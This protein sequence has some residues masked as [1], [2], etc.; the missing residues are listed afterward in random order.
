MKNDIKCPG[1]ITITRTYSSDNTRPV[2]I[3]VV[4][5][6][7]RIHVIEVRM[8]LEAFSRAVLGQGHIECELVGNPEQMSNFGSDRELVD[9]RIDLAEHKEKNLSELKDLMTR[10][11]ASFLLDG[12]KFHSTN[13]NNQTRS[14]SM[15]TTLVRY[16]KP[17]E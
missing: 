9:V 7:S 11:V 8:S 14:T 5:E 1:K 2:H 16:I 17:K 13:E 15:I 10:K 4:D 6:N 3:E 12:W